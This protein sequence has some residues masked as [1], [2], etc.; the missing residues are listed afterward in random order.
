MKNFLILIICILSL[1]VSGQN[2]VKPIVQMSIDF[3]IL[4]N[5][6]DSQDIINTEGVEFIRDN[7]IVDNSYKLTYKGDPLIFNTGQGKEGFFNHWTFEFIYVKVKSKKAQVLYKFIP[8]WNYC[9]GKSIL[10]Q[11]G[12]LFFII[13]LDFKLTENGW[14]IIDYEIKDIDFGE[15]SNENPI[16]CMKERYKPIN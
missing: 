1:S 6:L 3:Q 2:K 16:K 12:S 9:E 13:D 10:S 5:H 7:G 4:Q 15:D 11:D 14:T 8:N